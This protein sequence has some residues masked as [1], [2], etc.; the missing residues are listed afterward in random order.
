MCCCIDVASC[1]FMLWKAAPVREFVALQ[2]DLLFIVI[3]SLPPCFK[4]FLDLRQTLRWINFEFARW[5][6]FAWKMLATKVYSNFCQ[7]LLKTCCKFFLWWRTWFAQ[8]KHL[9]QLFVYFRLERARILF[10]FLCL[11]KHKDHWSKRQV[12]VSILTQKSFSVH[13]LAN[14]ESNLKYLQKR[15]PDGWYRL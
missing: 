8:L 14:M 3:C 11:L 5:Q 1:E 7:I 15:S 13:W 10:S 12:H 6:I 9:W 2:P 4:L